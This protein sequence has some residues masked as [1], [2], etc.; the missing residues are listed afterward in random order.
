[1]KK[2]YQ[3]IEE[4]GKT[5]PLLEGRAMK[6]VSTHASHTNREDEWYFGSKSLLFASKNSEIVDMW[7][8]KL[9]QMVEED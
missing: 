6:T 3:D 5:A 9:S 7:V 1:M 2:R 4:G 8:D